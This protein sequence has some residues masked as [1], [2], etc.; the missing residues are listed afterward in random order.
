MYC[1]AAGTT[2]FSILGE[3]S[4]RK[5][6]AIE[7]VAQGDL[8][9]AF[10]TYPEVLTY[11]GPAPWPQIFSFLFFAMLLSMGIGHSAAYIHPILVT[12]YDI[13]PV[14]FKTRGRKVLLTA[15]VCFIG[16][17]CGLIYT[18]PVRRKRYGNQ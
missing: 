5:G 10:V 8:G 2:V 13:F 7:Q 14:V 1:T 11:F 3:L 17:L 4:H 12:V 15:L 6:L 16:F 18:A 9:L